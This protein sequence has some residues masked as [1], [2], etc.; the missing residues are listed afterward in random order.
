MK[1]IVRLFSIVAFI[2]IAACVPARAAE[3]FR[4]DINPAL[5]YWQ[6]FAEWRTLPEADHGYVYTNQWQGRLLPD[7]LGKHLAKYDN[8]FKLIRR[9]AHSKVK[10]DWG[11]DLSD[12]PETLLPGLAKA[13]LAAQT[14]RLRVIWHLQRGD[15]ASARDEL[16]GVF[17]LG[18]NLST[19]GILISAL[20]Q[21]AIENIVIGAVAENLHQ[22]NPET[23]RQILAGLESAPARGTIAQCIPAERHSFAAWMLRKLDQFKAET[24]EDKAVVERMR[25]TMRKSFT[26]D[27]NTDPAIAD[28]II[29]A[30]GGTAEGLAAYIGQL[31]PLYDEA[32]E[33]MALPYDQYVPRVKAFAERVESHPNLL[34]GVFFP[35]FQKC[36][37]KEFAAQVTLAMLHAGIAY[38]IEGENALQRVKDPVL[39][40]PF[41]FS[42]LVVDG[43]DRGFILGSKLATRDFPERLAFIEKPGP[44]VQVIGKNAGT[45]AK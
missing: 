45:L 5:L 11:Y 39:N 10:C 3:S 34:V 36:R 25:E 12:G 30:S 20:V 14:A 42:R 18:R 4:T 1:L 43:V 15:Q 37:G 23:L 29:E 27:E 13:K 8:A 44:P 35:V 9:A 31:W 41:S 19:D 6:A 28:R 22:L 40:E 17:A 16:L 26:G 21:L 38:R 24:S 7:E 33:I 2:A 32:D